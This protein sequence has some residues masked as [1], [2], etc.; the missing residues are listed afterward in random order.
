VRNAPETALIYLNESNA[1]KLNAQLQQQHH[2][3]LKEFSSADN[4]KETIKRYDRTAYLKL[5]P[6]RFYQLKIHYDTLTLEA[7]NPNADIGAATQGADIDHIM[8]TRDFTE[9]AAKIEFIETE[10]GAEYAAFTPWLYGIARS[11]FGFVKMDWLNAHADILREVFDTITYDDDDGARFF[12]SKY[13][14]SLIEA[15]IR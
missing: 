10:R 9:A 13:D 11:S 8:K 4:T 6:V 1:D 14:R 15:N 2:I 7:A 5:P 3:S 12:S